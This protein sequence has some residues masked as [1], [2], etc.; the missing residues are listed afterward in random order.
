[1]RLF[2]KKSL[3][4]I[5]TCAGI[6]FYGIHPVFGHAKM[7]LDVYGTRQ[8]TADSVLRKFNDDLQKWVDRNVSEGINYGGP[9]DAVLE[10]KIISG[11]MKEGKFAWIGMAP[12]QYPNHNAVYV[13]ID[14]VDLKDR[15][16]R[17]SFL[18]Q[19]QGDIPDPE[20]LLKM[21]DAYNRLY[22]SFM[23]HA[24]RVHHYPSKF[25]EVNFWNTRPAISSSEWEKYENILMKK[26]PAHMDEIARVIHEDR[27]PKKRILAITLLKFAN[28]GHHVI[29]ILL[30]AIDDP[31]AG[32]RNDALLL[33]G[34]VL[35]R[36]PV[37]DFP[38]ERIVHSLDYPEET[39]RNKSLIV[40]HALIK[41][42]YPY[43]RRYI[44]RHAGAL[45][46]KCLRMKQPNH[47]D[48]A[49]QI[50]ETISGKSFGEYDY[51][52]WEQWTIQ[53]ATRA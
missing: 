10:Q 38:V 11:L 46:V 34:A 5:C 18:P 42:P 50:L 51:A 7:I 12:I 53:A 22:I 6:P 19:P 28:D 26:V 43:Y 8:I 49:Y 30:S 41:Q 52:A 9:G 2:I 3:L 29:D 40:I 45:L 24:N 20:G 13:T 31:H 25:K 21:A 27:D 1:M 39:D 16:E 4:I 44:I 15:K 33:L 48:M 17:L 36:V 32:V 14:A 37:K 35:Y 47:H 23:L